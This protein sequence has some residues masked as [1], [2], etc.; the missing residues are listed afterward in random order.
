MQFG[1]LCATSPA[2]ALYC[3]ERALNELRS[4]ANRRPY[5]KSERDSTVAP[6]TVP[7]SSFVDRYAIAL[8]R[9]R[10]Q[11]EEVLEGRSHGRLPI[12]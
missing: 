4:I 10:D 1:P 11:D 12:K 8:A 5:R 9:C 7:E 2:E 3:I 6:T